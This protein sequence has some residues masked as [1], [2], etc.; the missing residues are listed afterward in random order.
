MR[1]GA[2]NIIRCNNWITK[3]RDLL[4]NNGFVDVWMYP[5]SVNANVFIPIFKNRLIDMYIGL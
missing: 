1:N 2:E 4:Q 5:E 3:V